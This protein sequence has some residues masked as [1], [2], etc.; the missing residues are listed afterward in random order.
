MICGLQIFALLISR[1]FFF[2]LLCFVLMIISPLILEIWGK[3]RKK[4]RENTFLLLFSVWIPSYIP[5]KLW[6]IRTGILW[7]IFQLNTFPSLILGTK[8]PLGCVWLE[9]KSS[10]RR[11]RFIYIYIYIH[12]SFTARSLD[13]RSHPWINLIFCSCCFFFKSGSK[14]SWILSEKKEAR[15]LSFIYIFCLVFVVLFW[16]KEHVC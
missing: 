6:S 15:F 3:M 5:S 1:T 16:E 13:V 11:K 10:G 4:E 9:G 14:I 12:A 7:R 2:F 8:Q